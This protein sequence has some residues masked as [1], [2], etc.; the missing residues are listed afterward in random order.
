[1]EKIMETPKTLTT[2]I[3]TQ[4]GMQRSQD[5]VLQ[6]LNAPDLIGNEQ[7][8][9]NKLVN[10]ELLHDA[11]NITSEVK[12]ES[13][14]LTV[15]DEKM[16]IETVDIL[17]KS[18]ADRLLQSAKEDGFEVALQR[19]ADGD[20]DEYEEGELESKTIEDTG[21][22]KEGEP[23]S[24]MV[25]PGEVSKDPEYV[26]LQERNK[27]LLQIVESQKEQLRVANEQIKSR[28]ITIQQF[29]ENQKLQLLFMQA[30]L[31][32]EEDEDIKESILVAMISLTNFMIS[33]F[34]PDPQADE[35]EQGKSDQSDASK[36]SNVVN[37]I[38]VIEQQ[39]KKNKKRQIQVGNE[40]LQP[41]A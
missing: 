22:K 33:I 24:E 37:L 4:I 23:I 17:E 39:T 27:D 35:V 41:A 28:D 25:E 19:L 16:V 29:L 26:A 40:Q 3:A 32:K 13:D 21:D 38:E 18:S 8:G 1:M 20:F 2:G 36:P 10:E 9:N 15:A 11:K 31:E 34:F 6:G 12:N 7:V 14:S 5:H 30:L